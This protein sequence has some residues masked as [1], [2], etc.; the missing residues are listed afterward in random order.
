VDGTGL[1][2]LRARYL[3]VGV[4]RFLTRDPWEGTPSQPQ[5]Q[6]SFVYV[7]NNPSNLSDPS[8]LICVFGFGNCDEEPDLAVEL[9]RAIPIPS[10]FCLPGN[11]GCWGGDEYA[12]WLEDE[13]YPSLPEIGYWWWYH[14][15]Q[16][17][18]LP[19]DSLKTLMI[20]DWLFELG[21]EMRTFNENDSATQL[22]MRHNGVNEIREEFYNT[23]CE[24]A[25]GYYDAAHGKKGWAK[26]PV[27]VPAHIR[28]FI[29]TVLLIPD[30]VETIE[31]TIG[32]YKIEI[33]NNQDGTAKFNV[34]NIA[35]WQSGSFGT[36]ENKSRDETDPN[37]LCDQGCGG[38]LEQKF[39]WNETI[40]IERC[41]C[42]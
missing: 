20:E 33:S 18:G 41:G 4:G 24:Y 8:G 23:G 29:E 13:Y 6:N 17:W 3:D 11:L 30:S 27:A 19:E 34:E 39:E 5:T 26:V 42:Q 12:D 35:S 40:D 31:G 9:Y 7:L 36:I 1:V 25:S 14:P 22:L 37:W 38:N 32:S 16:A 2:Y 15:A 10:D 28:V 21:P